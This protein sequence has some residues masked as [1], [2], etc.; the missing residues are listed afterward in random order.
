MHVIKR[1]ENRMG[2]GWVLVLLG[3]GF[4]LAL[5]SLAAKQTAAQDDSWQIVRADYGWRDVR[6]NVTD[7]V[8]DL[9]GRGGVNGRVAVNN[10]TMGGDPAVGKDKSLRIIARNR[11]GEQ[12]EFNFNEGSWIDVT[13]FN[14][15]GGDADDRGGYA[16]RDHDRDRPPRDDDR[17]RDRDRDR[18]NI[19]GLQITRAFYGVHGQ[20]NNVTEIVRRLVREGRGEFRVSNE[21]L[22]GDPAPGRDKV[23]IVVYSF[24]GNET[25]CAVGEG[26]VLRLP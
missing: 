15:R 17:D 10:Q 8:R 5:A 24:Q 26:G 18:D 16:D 21:S 9:V 7:L 25:A 23:L 20:T 22:G 4:V 2:R 13:A 14:V 3:A 6:T 19:N 11:R 1:T 12:R